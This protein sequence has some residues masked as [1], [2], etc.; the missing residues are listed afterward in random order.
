MYMFN[1]KVSFETD[2]KNFPDFP[3]FPERIYQ[4]YFFSHAVYNMHV[5]FS[6]VRGK[7]K[8]RIMISYRWLILNSAIK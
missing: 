5:V 7:T 1:D 3:R 6:H 8:S 4:T 2:V